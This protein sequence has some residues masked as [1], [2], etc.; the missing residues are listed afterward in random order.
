MKRMMSL[1]YTGTFSAMI[2]AFSACA[3]DKDGNTIIN[4]DNSKTISINSNVNTGIN[5]GGGADDKNLIKGNGEIKTETRDL[6][7]FKALEL[8]GAFDVILS[9]GD[10]AKVKISIDS[11]I[12][13]HI[14]SKVR[15][16]KLAIG[17]DAPI[18]CKN[19]I[20]V[21]ITSPDEIGSVEE[22]GTCKFSIKDMTSSKFEMSLI[23]SSS[24]DISGKADSFEV[25]IQG[26]CSL[27]AKDFKTK[28]TSISVSGTAK[29]D[30]TV[31]DK[32][33]AKI[34][35]LGSIT[36][37]GDPKEVV[38]DISGLGKLNRK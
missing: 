8:A 11:N 25:E 10:S 20:K 12:L 9:K 30:I 23:G 3:A 35:G 15:N 32:L 19:A 4:N 16:G 17:I 24:A 21:E 34:A 22:S 36:Y 14:T 28:E 31:S 29:A 37:Y 7:K 1:A 18:S 2:F 38:K 5:L 6:E 26:T 13:P 27:N 33:T